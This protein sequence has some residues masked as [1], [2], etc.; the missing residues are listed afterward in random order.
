MKFNDLVQNLLE[1]LDIDK[2]LPKNFNVYSG[3]SCMLAAEL[4]TKKLLDQGISDFTIHE[5]YVKIKGWGNDK[6]EHTWIELKDGSKIDETIRQFFPKDLS[7]EDILRRVTYIK[8]KKQYTPTQYQKLCSD[9]PE[10][11]TKKHFIDEIQQRAP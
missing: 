5:G 4:L 8:S 6:I 1:N 2:T 10:E 7:I 3:G 9:F 11:D